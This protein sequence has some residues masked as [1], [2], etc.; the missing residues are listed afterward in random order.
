MQVR[1]FERYIP[2]RALPSS[3][4][5]M[6]MQYVRTSNVHEKESEYDQRISQAHTADQPTA[7]SGRFTD[8]LTVSLHQE[9]N[10]STATSSIFP[11]KMMVKLQRTLKYDITKQGQTTEPPQ[12][13]GPTLNNELTATEP[14][15]KRNLNY[16]ITKQGQT[17]EPPQSIGPTLNNELTATESSLKRTLKNDITKQGQT[18]EPPQSIGPTLNN[19]LTTTESSL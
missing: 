10:K 7:P 2:I 11:I 17:T 15:L 4:S 8:T 16:D 14:S 9:G 19:E 5:K 3:C 6:L 13:I 12:S 1:T 18:T